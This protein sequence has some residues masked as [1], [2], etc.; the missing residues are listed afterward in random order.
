MSWLLETVLLYM[1]G[2]MYLFKLWFSLNTCPGVGLLDHMLV[3]FLAFEGTSILFSTGAVPVYTPPAG[4]RVPFS[5]HPLQHLLFI[6]F[7]MMVI[8]TGM[9]WYLHCL[10]E[11]PTGRSKSGAH[12]GT[13]VSIFSHLP[14][15]LVFV[16]V[17]CPNKLLPLKSLSLVI[18]FQEIT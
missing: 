14:F 16:P 1:L 3:L 9:G 8:L 13:G 10:W 2:C 15:Y 5:P 12:S 18:T 4:R 17:C 7:V 11:F 6:G